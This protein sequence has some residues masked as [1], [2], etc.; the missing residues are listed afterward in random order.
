[1]ASSS[2]VSERKR[3]DI[4]RW[5]AMSFADR[6]GANLSL[7]VGQRGRAVYD[8]QQSAEKLLKAFLFANDFPVKKTHDIP[9]LMLDA[10]AIDPEI[11]KIRH[12]GVGAEEMAKFALCYRYPNS[13]GIDTASEQEAAGAIDFVDS[14]YKYLEQVW[15]KDVI[16]DAMEYAR[17][18][19]NPFENCDIESILE[20]LLANRGSR[21]RPSQKG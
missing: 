3:N 19:S 6:E 4:V 11:N 16:A 21:E 14:L 20:S 8:L 13:R 2:Q 9:F 15:G 5:L 1:M 17:V 7:F 12:V 10:V 18:H